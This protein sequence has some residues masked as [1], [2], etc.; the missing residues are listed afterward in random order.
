VRARVRLPS[1][2]ARRPAL[3]LDALVA[4]GAGGVLAAALLATMLW[5]FVLDVF[6]VRAAHRVGAGRAAAA[7][8]LP[9]VLFAVLGVLV[10]A[11]LLAALLTGA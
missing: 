7:V 11:A 9:M 1:P 3:G 2:G 8:V 5:S 4:P 6:A 10:L